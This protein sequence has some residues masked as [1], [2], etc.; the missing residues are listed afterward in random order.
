MKTVFEP[1]NRNH[2]FHVE[3][4]KDNETLYVKSLSNVLNGKFNFGFILEK[5]EALN[6]AQH[7]LKLYS[8]NG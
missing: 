1:L 3:K 5:K 7:I 2:A 6:L 8:N 4:D